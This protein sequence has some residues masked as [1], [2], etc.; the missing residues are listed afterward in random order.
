LTLAGQCPRIRAQ[1]FLLLDIS[2]GDSYPHAAPTLSAV[3]PGSG[4]DRSDDDPAENG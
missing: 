2:S 4:G 3:V 1:R